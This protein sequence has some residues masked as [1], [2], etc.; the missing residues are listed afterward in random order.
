MLGTSGA[1]CAFGTA[2]PTD[3]R[4]SPR[5]ASPSSR[6]CLPALSLRMSDEVARSVPED[7]PRIGVTHRISGVHVD[8]PRA[9]AAQHTIGMVTHDPQYASHADRTVQLF[10]ARVGEEQVAGAWCQ[11]S[12]TPRVPS[13]SLTPDT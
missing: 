7:P 3:G 9:P 11:V 13:T 10:D 8:I 5:L 1:V 6:K 2:N 4:A 12:E